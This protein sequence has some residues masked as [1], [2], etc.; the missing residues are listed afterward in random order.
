MDNVHKITK[1]SVIIQIQ[2][3][4][5]MFYT[6][7]VHYSLGLRCCCLESLRS[8]FENGKH[9]SFCSNSHMHSK[10]KIFLLSWIPFLVIFSSDPP[11]L[12]LGLARDLPPGGMYTHT[13]RGVFRKGGGGQGGQHHPPSPW[14]SLL[15]FPKW[16]TTYKKKREKRLYV[17]LI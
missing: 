12:E 15:R 8:R 17:Y 14:F 11:H 13:N 7:Y 5:L 3:P 4:S 1:L 6:W 10:N 16:K 9:F 2:P